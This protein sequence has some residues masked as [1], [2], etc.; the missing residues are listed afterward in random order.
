MKSLQLRTADYQSEAEHPFKDK[1]TGNNRFVHMLNGT[2][3][4]VSGL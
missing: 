4:A 2:A 3:I 1:Q